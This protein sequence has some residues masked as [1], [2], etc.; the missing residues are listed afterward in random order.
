MSRPAACG[1]DDH[2]GS[3]HATGMSRDLR[4]RAAAR[5]GAPGRCR[6]SHHGCPRP[7]RG[8]GLWRARLNRRHR[9]ADLAPASAAD[10]AARLLGASPVQAPVSGSYA[11]LAALAGHLDAAELALLADALDHGRDVRIRYRNK[12]GNRSFRDIAPRELDGRWLDSWCY[13]R[14]GERDFTVAGI[15]AVSPVG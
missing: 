11:A 7:R 9:D 5:R 3:S 10:L 12:D 2:R 15:E 14:A 13:L 4:R 6:G 1:D 8:S